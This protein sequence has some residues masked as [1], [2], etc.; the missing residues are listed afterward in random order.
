MDEDKNGGL[1]TQDEPDGQAV[2]ATELHN[3]DDSAG[4]A[5]LPQIGE[6]NHTIVDDDDGVEQPGKTMDS[7]FGPDDYS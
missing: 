6:E 2:S 1:N 7:G 5:P 3:P 4:E